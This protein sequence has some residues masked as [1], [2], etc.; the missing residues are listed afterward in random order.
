M[1]QTCLNIVITGN[2]GTGKTTFA[3]LLFRFL[4]AY[5]VLKK[6]TFVECNAL[7]L[8]AKYVGHTSDN[9]KRK[10]Q[11]A[12][13]G[14]LFLD[15]AYALAAERGAE[16]DS[17]SNEAIR[18]LLTEVENN[19]TGLLVVLA[20]YKDKMKLLMAAD[21]GMPRR[22]PQSLHLADYTPAQLADICRR[23]AKKRFGMTLA[24]GLE[25]KLVEEFE[26]K[27]FVDIANQNGG[28]AVNLVE[29]ATGRLAERVMAAGMQ[30]QQ[31][32]AVAA[33][34]GGGGDAAAVAAAAAA[35]DPG[36][37]ANRT[38]RAVDFGISDDSADQDAI[39]EIEEEVAGM[40]GMD[41]IK[42]FFANVRKKVQYV[43]AGGQPQVLRTCLNM[44]VTGNP[45]TG[46]TTFARLLFRFLRAYG[47][48]KK[49][50]FV[51]VN[52][53]ELKGQ[54]LGQTCVNVRSI[55][56]SALGGCLFLDEAYALAGDGRAD[57]FSNEAIRTLLTEVEN[58]RTGLLVVLAG[59]K[60]KMG[61]LMAADPGMPR[62]FPQSLH[63]ADYTPTQIACI[64]DKVAKERFGMALADGLREQLVAH[65]AD[66]FAH[67]IPKQNGGL[68]VNEVENATARLV[69]RVMVEQTAAAAG[70]GWEVDLQSDASKVL[71]AS[72]FGIA[73][74]RDF[75]S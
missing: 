16:S 18:T 68:A 8:K 28:L 69:E 44:V 6:D 73:R 32:A 53:L 48:L 19:R 54:Y 13:G 58:N 38:L 2:P 35:A 64:C 56:Q 46:K 21:P 34:A 65:F 4:R 42:R 22:F 15:E 40:V 36:S 3:R 47:V 50:N 30:Q 75:T 41:D 1:L 66:H 17:F 29:N 10:V 31:Q 74:V 71:V 14:C 51:E 57:A 20:G 70:D 67:E 7:E 26:G 39:D 25:A 60:D 59:Y 11:S 9:V 55:V 33:A 23:V 72:D 43:A 27:Y 12:L 49:D 62:R 45:G 52:A 24:E 37:A 61:T 5:G 63:L